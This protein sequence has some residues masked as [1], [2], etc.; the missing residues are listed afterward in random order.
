MNAPLRKNAFLISGRALRND[1]RMGGTPTTLSLPAETKEGAHVHDQFGEW[2]RLAKLT[3][4]HELLAR[5]WGGVEAFVADADESDV[6]DLARLFNELPVKSESFLSGFR[7]AFQAADAAFPM[8]DNDLE[9]AVLAG[10]CL[11]EITNVGDAK[12]GNSFLR[13]TLSQS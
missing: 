3:P 8:K 2:Y 1:T 13:G 11:S 9:L 10:A 12:T 4:E 6:F 5:R 7:G